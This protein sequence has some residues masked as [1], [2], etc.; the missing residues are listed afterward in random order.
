MATPGCQVC[1]T[2]RAAS[3]GSREGR[4]GRKE[5]RC[6]AEPVRPAPAARHAPAS[7]LDPRHLAARAVSE[8]SHLPSSPSSA[9]LSPPPLV[10]SFS[11]LTLASLASAHSAAAFPSAPDA[12]ARARPRP[13]SNCGSAGSLTR[14]QGCSCLKAFFRLATTQSQRPTNPKGTKRA[15]P[16]VLL[17]DRAWGAASTSHLPAGT[18]SSRPRNLG[19]NHWG[20]RVHPLARCDFLTPLTPPRDWRG[21]TE[22]P[23][24]LPPLQSLGRGS[25]R[26][27]VQPIVSLRPRNPAFSSPRP[28]RAHAPHGRPER[29]GGG[30]LRAPGACGHRG[31]GWQRVSA[32]GRLAESAQ[33]CGAQ[34]ARTPGDEA[35]G[36]SVPGRG[37]T[38]HRRRGPGGLGVGGGARR[39]PN[40]QPWSPQ[41]PRVATSKQ[42]R[43]RARARRRGTSSRGPR[44]RARARLQ[45]LPRW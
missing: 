5:T 18:P 25:L 44:A 41:P 17:S 8:P 3:T 22:A 9:F 26:V 35:Q 1:S 21:A 2:D 29:P 24:L 34:V 13:P 19:L 16:L 28:P 45:L 10:L 36:L 7:P 40:P 12:P 4:D 30:G 31:R 6:L 38:G 20:R 15:E 42:S 33:A 27:R 14:A 39:P 23:A 32:R 43:E 11:Y 37:G